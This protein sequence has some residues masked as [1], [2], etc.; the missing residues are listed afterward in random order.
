MGV[1]EWP[2]KKGVGAEQPKGRK[3]KGMTN[4]KHSTNLQI[5]KL[6]TCGHQC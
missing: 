5:K 4:F 1:G 3:D 2:E 6:L